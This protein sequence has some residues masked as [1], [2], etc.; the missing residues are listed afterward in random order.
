MYRALYAHRV[1]HLRGARICT[2]LAACM[3]LAPAWALDLRQA[4]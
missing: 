3:V 2:V 1:G 4:L